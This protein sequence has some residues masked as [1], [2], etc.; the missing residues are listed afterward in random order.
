MKVDNQPISDRVSQVET[1]EAGL[2]I[3]MANENKAGS[4]ARQAAATGWGTVANQRKIAG[5]NISADKNEAALGAWQYVGT[6][7][8]APWQ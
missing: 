8:E 4:G 7:E 2:I 5:A 1:T 6:A 3:I